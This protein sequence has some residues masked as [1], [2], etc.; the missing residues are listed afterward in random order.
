MSVVVRVL[1][2]DARI[3]DAAKLRS[4]LTGALGEDGYTLDHVLTGMAAQVRLG[5]RPPPHVVLIDAAHPDLSYLATKIKDD[6]NTDSVTILTWGDSGT[7]GE[8]ARLLSRIVQSGSERP[9]SLDSWSG[10]L[11]GVR[12]DVDG[13]LADIRL[14]R[15]VVGGI[16]AEVGTLRSE[17]REGFARLE[18]I[19]ATPGIHVRAVVAAGAWVG[20]R[21]DAHPWMAVLLLVA[22]GVLSFTAWATAGTVT[23]TISASVADLLKLDWVG[24]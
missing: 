13:A 6:P 24:R 4:R 1:L 16:G 9:S 5:V 14:G 10:M 19:I 12:R 23:A 2:V 11:A 17:M 22:T 7:P 3:G 18:A 15:E 8:M 20:A 21:W